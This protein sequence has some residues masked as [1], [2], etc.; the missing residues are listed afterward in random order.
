MERGVTKTKGLFGSEN[1]PPPQV[2]FVI[3]GSPTSSNPIKAFQQGLNEP[4]D[5]SYAVMGVR[6]TDCGYLELSTE[7]NPL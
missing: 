1:S 4:G 3:P 2:L 6:C 7:E 5:R